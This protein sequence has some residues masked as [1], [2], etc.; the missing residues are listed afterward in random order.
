MRVPPMNN[1]EIR[2]KKLHNRRE[3]S[4]DLA[5]RALIKR[6]TLIKHAN[7]KLNTNS[8]RAII[9]AGTQGH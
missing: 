9:R 7:I 1:F 2:M 8:T 3:M 4:Q 6:G 5:Q